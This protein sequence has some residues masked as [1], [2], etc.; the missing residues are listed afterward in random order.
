LHPEALYD[1][2]QGEQPKLKP[3]PTAKPNLWQRITGK[4]PPVTAKLN[5]PSDWPEQEVA[6]IG[7]EIN[8]RN[9]DLAH[10]IL[11]GTLDA[12]VGSGSIFQ[13]WFMKEH[14]AINLDGENFAFSND[15]LPE[16]AQLLGQVDTARVMTGFKQWLLKEGDNHEPS[17]E[18]CEQIFKEYRQF[19]AAIKEAIE[20][21]QALIW[22]AC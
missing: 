11:N 6:Q 10:C 15:Q 7:P 2:F 22:I 20:R 13:T 18:E 3:A 16:L 5:V 19:H 17:E 4:L 9:A 14:S 21:D 8:H 1:Y 12:V